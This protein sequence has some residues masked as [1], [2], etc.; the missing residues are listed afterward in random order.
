MA[1]SMSR[2]VK[3]FDSALA[4]YSIAAAG[5]ATTSEAKK[6]RAPRTIVEY[7]ISTEFRCNYEELGEIKVESGRA[8]I[9]IYLLIRLVNLLLFPA[10]HDGTWLE[11]V[12]QYFEHYLS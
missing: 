6:A 11:V 5:K 4:A 8:L 2:R 9:L 10:L 3:A 7:L 1:A 12:S